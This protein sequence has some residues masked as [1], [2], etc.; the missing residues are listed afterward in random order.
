M[1][2]L[3]RTSSFVVDKLEQLFYK[4]GCFVSKHPKRVIFGCLLITALSALGFFN[5]RA[6]S[7]AEKLWISPKSPYISDKELLD[8]H[9]P[10]NTRHNIALFVAEKNIL[11]PDSLLHMLE[12]HN[13]VLEIKADN[14][15]WTDICYRIPIA[16]IFLTKRRKKRQIAIVNTTFLVNPVASA[17]QN[18]ERIPKLINDD[19]NQKGNAGHKCRATPLSP[20]NFRIFE[21]G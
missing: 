8:T 12:L 13:K 18:T 6:E 16:D 15:T 11:T 21:R 20:N 14:K 17:V 5:L 9:F 7:R 3:K 1:A 10:R 19:L 2:I 4:W